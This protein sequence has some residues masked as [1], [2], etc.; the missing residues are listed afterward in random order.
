MIL[1]KTQAHQIEGPWFWIVFI[2]PWHTSDVI[3]DYNLFCK[4]EASSVF[5]TGG[6]SHRCSS[7]GL[8]SILT[9]VVHVGQFL[10]AWSP[11]VEVVVV[12]VSVRAA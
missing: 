7:S 5:L 1:I 10:K 12:L 8:Q 9:W 3:P 11:V 6:V 4:P 2:F